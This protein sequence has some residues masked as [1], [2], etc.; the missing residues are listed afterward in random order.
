MVRGAGGR[1]DRKE[2]E[3]HKGH[4]VP[5]RTRGSEARWGDVDAWP[6]A[7]LAVTT[8]SPSSIPRASLAP[9]RDLWQGSYF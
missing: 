2:A 9:E 5:L 7:Y 8:A 6:G 1:R 3:D 4:L